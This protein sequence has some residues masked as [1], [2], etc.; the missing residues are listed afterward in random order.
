MN[1]YNKQCIFKEKIKRKEYNEYERIQ[2]NTND[3]DSDK[4]KEYKEISTNVDT[5]KDGLSLVR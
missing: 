5:K 3:T 1:I 2:T 4:D